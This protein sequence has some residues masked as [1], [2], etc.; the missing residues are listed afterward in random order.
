LFLYRICSGSL[1]SHATLEK[2]VWDLLLARVLVD[3]T[4]VLL[5]ETDAMIWSEWVRLIPDKFCFGVLFS[6][7]AIKS[8]CFPSSTRTLVLRRPSVF[9][10]IDCQRCAVCVT[11]RAREIRQ[12]VR[13][14]PAMWR[15]S[16]G[17]EPW[18]VCIY[19]VL[20]R[21]LFGRLIEFRNSC[22]AAV[23]EHWPKCVMHDK[24]FFLS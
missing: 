24:F 22:F 17:W 11:H 13:L 14:S 9:M 10:L 20:F 19:P 1:M 6:R 16:S 2:S 3:P 4:L 23:R 12:E 21:R 8:S 18:H 5:S 15:G 7:D